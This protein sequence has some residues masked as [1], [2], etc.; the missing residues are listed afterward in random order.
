[1]RIKKKYSSPTSG[2]IRFAIKTSCLLNASGNVDDYEVVSPFN[3][4]E[5]MVSPDEFGPLC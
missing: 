2:A 3:V 5:D 1:M 4:I